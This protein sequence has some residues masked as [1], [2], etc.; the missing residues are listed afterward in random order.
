[1]LFIAQVFDNNIN[2]NTVDVK[3]NN[4]GEFDND[5]DA[6]NPY[7]DPYDSVRESTSS[8]VST[9]K[10]SH[11]DIDSKNIETIIEQEPIYS[12]LDQNTTTSQITYV[13]VADND[14][15]EES[16]YEPITPTITTNRN[17][18]KESGKTKFPDRPPPPP[19]ASPRQVNKKKN[20]KEDQLLKATKERSAIKTHNSLNHNHNNNNNSQTLIPVIVKSSESSDDLN[21]SPHSFMGDMDIT[22]GHQSKGSPTSSSKGKMKSKGT[23]NQPLF[24]YASKPDGHEIEDTRSI[25]SVSSHKERTQSYDII[26]STLTQKPAPE[27]ITIP[28]TVVKRSASDDEENDEATVIKIERITPGDSEY[29]TTPPTSRQMDDERKMKNLLGVRHSPSPSSTSGSRRPMTERRSNGDDD[30]DVFRNHYHRSQRER[31]VQSEIFLDN[32]Q[33]RETAGYSRNWFS[34]VNPKSTTPRASHNNGKASNSEGLKDQ[35]RSSPRDFDHHRHSQYSPMSSHEVKASRRDN[36]NSPN[37]GRG[38][39][40]DSSSWRNDHPSNYDDNPYSGRG[41]DPKGGYPPSWRASSYEGYLRPHDFDARFDYYT[42][43]NQEDPR[44]RNGK[45]KKP[46]RRI[47]SHQPT[48]ESSTK[49]NSS[50]S[51]SASSRVR[52]FF[53]AAKRT[54][55]K[56]KTVSNDHHYSIKRQDYYEKNIGDV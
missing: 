11:N 24:V 8:D 1:M 35:G 42:D 33:P 3:N 27:Q 22:D 9:K 12:N 49:E 41:G 6:D 16:I 14:N 56:N 7:E 39:S 34:E 25:R 43:T 2:N 55:R 29:N 31:R 15:E 54:L 13:E 10:P 51:S 20:P 19:P 5:D 32:Y 53:R 17:D 38:P 26:L 21:Y 48:M 40:S 23:K 44:M 36:Y 52:G 46:L 30:D 18:I 37:N 50:S 47:N 4:D 28:T 45:K